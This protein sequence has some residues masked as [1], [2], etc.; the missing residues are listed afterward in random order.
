[1]VPILVVY[2]GFCPYLGLKTESSWGMYS[3]LRTEIRPNHVFM[4]AWLQVAGYQQDLVE[5]LE[6]SLPNLQRYQRE[7]L[8]L[9]FAEFRRI[10][11]AAAGDFTVTYER[12]GTVRHLQSTNGTSNDA[13]VTTSPG[14]LT[15]TLLIFRPIDSQGPMKCRH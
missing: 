4:P 1:V 14:W 13:S 15:E 12:G 11:R 10:S 6:T 5:I 2:N 3:N 9:N 8:L 7:G